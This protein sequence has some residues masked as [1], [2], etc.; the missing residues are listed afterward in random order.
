M[1]KKQTPDQ[2]LPEK[3]FQELCQRGEK[4][5]ALMKSGKHQ[6]ALKSYLA[7]IAELEK[8]GEMDSYLSAKLTLGALHAYVKVGDYKN[9]FSV[10]NATLEESV[11]GIGIYALESA[12]TA[13]QDM[14]TYDMLCAFLHTLADADKREAASAVNQYL[15]RVC[16]QAIEEGNMAVAKIAI[17]NWKIHLRDLFGSALPLDIAKPMI[18]FSQ[19]LDPMIKSAELDFPAPASWKR[20]K[21][22]REMSYVADL[23]ALKEASQKAKAK[24]RS[25]S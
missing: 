11:F 15:S 12:Q 9:A 19:S 13:I 6:E 10:W 20:P 8:S 17:G 7:I 1:S 3:R 25:A 23:Q 5:D 18:K 21:T 22:F 16:E 2:L 4:A 24:K 14:V